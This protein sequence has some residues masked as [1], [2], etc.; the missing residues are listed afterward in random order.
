M[1]TDKHTFN[2]DFKTQKIL[3]IS[4]ITFFILG[5]FLMIIK[6]NREIFLYLNGDQGVFLDHFFK[7]ATYLGDGIF[8]AVIFIF[9]FFIRFGYALDFAFSA[10]LSTLFVQSGKRLI[11]ADAKRPLSEL[12]SELVHLV[13]GVDVHMARSFPS[14]HSTSAMLIFFFLALIV[15]NRFLKTLMILLAFLGGYTRIYLSQHFFKDVYAGF[16]IAIL[17]IL[18]VAFIRN[19]IGEPDWY[20]KKIKV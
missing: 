2:L 3:F 15:K 7:Y 16:A 5:A 19:R 9:L 13:K 8:Y 10:G 1:N 20:R 18:I 11:F 12:G 14:G 4:M 6:T 17:S